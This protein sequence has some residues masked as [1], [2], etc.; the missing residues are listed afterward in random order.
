VPKNRVR[1][2]IF[3]HIHLI[4]NTGFLEDLFRQTKALRALQ[5]GRIR[6]VAYTLA[7]TQYPY[8][9]NNSE[10][11]QEAIDWHQ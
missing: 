10:I 3:Y 1:L 5:G 6:G 11:S 9:S 7:E 2:I 8:Q 4:E